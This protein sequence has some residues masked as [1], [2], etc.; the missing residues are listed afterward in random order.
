MIRDFFIN[1]IGLKIIALALAI[2]TWLY[3]YFEVRPIP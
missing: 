2:I 3:V 1:N